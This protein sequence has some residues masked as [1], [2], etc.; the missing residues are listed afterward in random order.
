[1]RVGP[2][3]RLSTKELMLLNC[4][5]GQDKSPLD[6]KDIKPVNPKGNQPCAFIGKTVLKLKLHYFGDLIEEQTHWKRLSYWKRLSARGEGV[7][8]DEMD[9]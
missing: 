3:R 2:Q 7:S 8:E 1:M 6:C 9:G 4:G 5:T